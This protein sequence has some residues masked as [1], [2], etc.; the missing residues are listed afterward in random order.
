[1]CSRVVIMV[2]YPHTQTVGFTCTLLYQDREQRNERRKILRGERGRSI[3]DVCSKAV[4]AH[5][6]NWTETGSPTDDSMPSDTKCG[7]EHKQL[8]HKPFP[9][10]IKAPLLLEPS[11]TRLSTWLIMFS[12]SFRHSLTSHPSGLLFEHEK[13]GCL[14]DLSYI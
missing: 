2:T 6:H 5:C 3:T 10:M 1:M 12:I 11:E 13:Q 14:S 7:S 4:S 8:W 9:D